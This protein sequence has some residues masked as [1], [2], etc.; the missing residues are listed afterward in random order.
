M[1]SVDGKTFPQTGVGGTSAKCGENVR[2]NLDPEEWEVRARAD[3]A[4]VD[5]GKRVISYSEGR[6]HGRKY[7][8]VQA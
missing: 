1:S 3:A 8:A 2:G 5:G 6:R 7:S 4:S